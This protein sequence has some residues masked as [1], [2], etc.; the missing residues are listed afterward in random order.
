[1]SGQTYIQTDSQ[2][3]G[4]LTLQRVDV[5]VFPFHR[6]RNNLVVFLV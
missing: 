2:R 4:G 6:L 1:M 3:D 5:I